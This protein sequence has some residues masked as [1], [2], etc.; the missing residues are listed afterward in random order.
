MRF[1]K[2]KRSSNKIEDDLPQQL[3]TCVLGCLL[4]RS[5]L[6][7]R[8]E[9]RMHDE[10]LQDTLVFDFELAVRCC[11]NNVHWGSKLISRQ[12]CAIHQ[13]ACFC[14]ILHRLGTSNDFVPMFER[15]S[16]FRVFIRHVRTFL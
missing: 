4:R 6:R 12:T 9:F 8:H 1:L 14:T 13:F 5:G 15:Q 3:R 11:L 7:V 16:I 2:L 10:R